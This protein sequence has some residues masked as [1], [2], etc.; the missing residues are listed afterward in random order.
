MN[1]ENYYKYDE[2]KEYFND[3][4]EEHDKE[5]IKENI[6]DLHHHAFNTD[7]YIIGT[8]RAAEW[9]SNRVFEVIKIIKEYENM[10]SCEITDFSEPE[11][12]VN[13]YVYIVGEYIVDDYINS[14]EEK[15]A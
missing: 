3:F 12:V 10:L 8:Y 11:K 13:M 4:I 5:W 1:I 7:Y 9:L 6:D 14:L 2:I 15:K